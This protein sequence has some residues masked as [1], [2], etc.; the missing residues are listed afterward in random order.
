[1]VTNAVESD[2]NTDDL[3]KASESTLDFWDNEDDEV[4]DNVYYIDSR[5][6]DRM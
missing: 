5:K 1:M 6:R 4:W 2:S 3:I